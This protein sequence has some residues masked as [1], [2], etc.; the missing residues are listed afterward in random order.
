[1]H[2]EGYDYTFHNDLKTWQGAQEFCTQ[3][4]SNLVMEKSVSVYNFVNL[5][6]GNES[7][8]IGV[9]DKSVEDQ[10][11]YVDGSLVTLTFWAQGQ[12]DN[13]GGEDCVHHS[14]NQWKWNDNECSNKLKFLCQKGRRK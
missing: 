13:S 6:W 11:E 10:F 7:F 8:W 9:H 2:H 1:M 5:T 12:P 4:G 14:G 3:E